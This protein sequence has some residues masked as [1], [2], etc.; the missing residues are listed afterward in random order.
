MGREKAGKRK[1]EKNEGKVKENGGNWCVGGKAGPYLFIVSKKSLLLLVPR[2]F[3]SKKSMLSMG[4]M[5]ANSLRKIHT[6]FS[7]S[8]SS[9]S[10]SFLVPLRLMSMAGNMRFSAR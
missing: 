8:S 2:I 3:S 10:S 7:T 6:L 9:N 1:V 4:C 5:G